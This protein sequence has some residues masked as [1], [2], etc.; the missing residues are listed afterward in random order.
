MTSARCDQAEDRCCEAEVGWVLLRI[1]PPSEA[2]ELWPTLVGHP[3]GFCPHCFPLTV[4][5]V[6]RFCPHLERQADKLPT[7]I[8][9]Y[10]FKETEGVHVTAYLEFM[11]QNQLY[12]P[13]SRDT[14]NHLNQLSPF[15]SSWK[16]H[17]Y[18]GIQQLCT[19]TPAGAGSAPVK[20]V[21]RGRNR[22]GK[23]ENQHKKT[24]RKTY[25]VNQQHF[26]WGLHWFTLK[27]VH[28]DPLSY[29]Q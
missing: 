8:A 19:P 21:Q 15:P 2:Q 16:A 10:H 13:S 29:L 28:V 1:Q 27:N 7:S 23:W 24:T 20:C 3:E 18:I 14:V 22:N 4:M 12:R 25:L 11:G 5:K 17:K 26:I 9:N 6:K